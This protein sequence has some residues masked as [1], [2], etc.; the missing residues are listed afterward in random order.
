[1]CVR[2][3]VCLPRAHVCA[4]VSAQPR[5]PPRAPIQALCFVQAWCARASVCA[6]QCR[7]T[8]VGVCLRVEKAL[9]R[10]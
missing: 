5:P 4:R 1:M 2:V 10:I 3:C 8:S 7:V 9:H 6:T